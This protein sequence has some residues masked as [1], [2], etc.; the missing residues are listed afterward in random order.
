MGDAVSFTKNAHFNNRIQ[1]DVSA[2]N[3][4]PPGKLIESYTSKGRNFEIWLGEL[5]DPGV[6]VILERLQ[7]FVSFFIEGGTPLALDDAEWTVARWRVF[8]V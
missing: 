6:Q 2:Q 8:F 1:A 5:A 3:F 7:I 4:K